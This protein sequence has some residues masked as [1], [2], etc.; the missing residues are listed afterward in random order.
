MR[1][2]VLLHKDEEGDDNDISVIVPWLEGTY[3]QGSDRDEALANAKE[4][5][6]LTLLTYLDIGKRLPDWEYLPYEL[7]FVDVDVP[8]VEKG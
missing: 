2:A 6:E 8:E 1:F 7:A 5:I 3:T 4:A